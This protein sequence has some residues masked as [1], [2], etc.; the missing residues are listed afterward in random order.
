MA[1]S[2]L[3]L[4]KQD[5]KPTSLGRRFGSAAFGGFASG[6]VFGV[7]WYVLLLFSEGK[8]L[9]FWWLMPLGVGLGAVAGFA[10]GRWRAKD[11]LELLSG[12]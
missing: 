3:E 2:D 8:M 5:R 11:I 4:L 9:S 12:L 7:V 6:I 10:L 1:T